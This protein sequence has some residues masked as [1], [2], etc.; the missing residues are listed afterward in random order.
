M[1]TLI[2]LLVISLLLTACAPSIQNSV[3]ADFVK[4][5]TSALQQSEYVIQPGD[6]LEI[7]FFYN[8]ELNE[9]LTVRPDGRIT[10]QLA[11]EV[12]AA[13]L[14]PAQLTVSLTNTYSKELANPGIAV[15]IRSFT[16][17]RVY[18]DGEVNKPGMI[19]LSSS[20]TVLQS[21]A[22]AGGFKNTARQGEVLIIRKSGEKKPLTIVVNL[23]D[24]IYGSDTGQ[25]ITL[26]SY[27]IVY[28]PKSAIANINQFVDQYIR[29]NIPVNFGLS[30]GFGF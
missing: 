1:S 2:K 8:P 7:K 30:Y 9:L 14:T 27:D 4:S 19:N 23:K 29:Q 22:E 13:G 20:M 26:A 25:D 15:I 10:L 17:Q 24:A 21:I 16:S 3:N 6:Q 11:Q 18:V 5:R 28:V 12:M